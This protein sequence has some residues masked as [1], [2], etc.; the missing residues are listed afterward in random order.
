MIEIRTWKKK[1]II[2]ILLPDLKQE[3][4]WN[5]PTWEGPLKNF[6]FLAIRKLEYSEISHQ[7]PRLA[8]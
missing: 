2:E 1:S 8:M 7:N 4:A 3:F 6:E 5:F